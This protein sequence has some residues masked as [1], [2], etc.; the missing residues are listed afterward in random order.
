M[1]IARA[2]RAWTTLLVVLVA[3]AVPA[4]GALPTV[5]EGFKV[6]LVA[7]V[8]AVTYPCQIATAPDGALFVAEDPMDQVGPYEADHGRILLF[9]EGKEPIV[10][11]EGFRAIFGMAWHDGAL[12]VMHMPRLTVLRDTNG[13]GKADKKVDLFKDLGPGPKALNDH[14]VSGIQFGM[15]GWLY[16]SVGDKGVPGVHGIDGRTAQLLGGGTMR[17]RPDGTG[18]EVISNGTRNHLEPNL[19]A[20][21]NIFTYDNTDD[22]LGWWT[23]V[24]H[25]IDGGYFG[26][27]YDYHDRTDRHLPRMAEFGGGSPCGGILYKEDAWPEEYRGRGFW[28]EWG[29]RH[30]AAIK[31]APDGSTFKLADYKKFV[32]PAPGESMNPLDL[33]LSY[34]GKTLYIAD[35]GM[36]GW[37][38]KTEKVGRIYAVTYTGK[39]ETKPRGKDSDPIPAQITALAHASFNERIRAQTALI[40]QGQAAIAPVTTALL[41]PKTDPV[42][43]RHLI[44][45]LD[46]LA[47]GT[48]VATGPLVTALG[49]PVADVRAQAARAFGLRGV[50]TAVEPLITA[51]KD[52]DPTVRLQA[53]IALGRIKDARAIPA[54]LPV[55][56]DPDTYLAFSARTALRRIHDWKAAAS[57]VSPSAD[58]K[59]RL[60]VLLTLENQYDLDAAGLLKS[61]ATDRSRPV[62]ERV[63]ALVYLAQVHRKAPP[64]DGSWW[65]TRPAAG[66]PPE[67]TI[68]WAGTGLVVGTV[69]TA[70][71]D[72]ETPIR[73]AAVTA[74]KGMNDRDALVKLREQFTSDP[75]PGVR[76]EIALALGAMSDKAALPI[77]IAALRDLKAPEEVRDAALASVETIGS[78]D[79]VQALNELLVEPGLKADR[80]ARVIAALGRFKAKSAISAIVR[81]LGSPDAKVRTSAVEAIGLIG[82]TSAASKIRPLLKDTVPE[83]RK[84]AIVAIGL[85]KDRESIPALIAVADDESTRYEATIALA[86]LPEI[87][88]LHVY[89]RGLGD[90]SPEVRKA[91]ATAMLAIR[92]QALPILEQLAKRKEL[93]P[94][95]LPELRKV[96]TSIQPVAKWQVVG[97]FPAKARPP[98]RPG[99]A[100]DVKKPVVLPDGKKLEWKAVTAVDPQGQIDVNQ[101]FGDN[102]DKSVFAYAEV[103]SPTAR[104]ARMA[105][106]SDDTLLVWVN[107]KQVYKFEDNRSFTP[108]VDSVEVS[109][110]KGVNRVFLR[111]GNG[112]GPW[113]FSV[114]FTGTTGEYAFLKGPAEGGFNPDK[115][116]A[117]A[118]EGKGKADHGKA[119]FS[120]LK[121]VA[122]IKCHAANG[123]GGMVG[124][125]LSAV[126]LKYPREELITSVLYPSQKISSGY[127]PIVIATAD[128]KV[129]T[130]IVKAETADSIE[131]EDGEAKRVKVPKSD[132][133]G[134]K[135][136]DV[137]LM[138]NGLTEGLSAADFA[139]LIAYLETLKDTAALHA[140]A[141]GTAKP[142]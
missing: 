70:L 12:Y 30:V 35:W 40:K 13:D 132:I 7:A 98:V 68:A 15:D 14:I 54:I 53:I 136:S 22:G 26:Y 140:P 49:S 61:V 48:P 75:D 32:E 102:G 137:S 122:C 79:A 78:N 24:T 4:L 9:R 27:P 142:K 104:T 115:F 37:G 99:A 85:L 123:K 80:Q 52:A 139:D 89:L 128:G 57:G 43:K 107:G 100:I 73:L 29:K 6:R 127:E 112:G 45:T 120:D 118:M 110:V 121:G 23:R 36:G 83:V 77:L 47:G 3:G 87:R 119:L 2:R 28:A 91:T 1:R 18:I 67:K 10:Y 66:K 44:W 42:A 94:S 19:D 135:M 82:E 63:K 141:A 56:A 130:G 88:S 117:V 76:R 46:G 97:T 16:I 34:D 109:L 51:L 60:G 39:V 124:P 86:S 33:A 41:D 106:G 131:I 126:G 116:R 105:V 20:R 65:G 90:K 103:T 81:T 129:L 108:E 114:G 11:A 138:P 72:S 69:V 71:S 55:V 64:W 95:S 31:F 93:A 8:P 113:A 5:P 38:S 134:R 21:D 58:A 96:Y 101:L 133:D 84:A 17:C 50:A 59:V 25:Q 111:C 92:E 74:L 125:E 62:A